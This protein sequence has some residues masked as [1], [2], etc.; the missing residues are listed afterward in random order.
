M[1]LPVR[2]ASS[3]KHFI[4]QIDLRYIK[5]EE[6]VLNYKVC[7]SLVQVMGINKINDLNYRKYSMC[8]CLIMI[9]LDKLLAADT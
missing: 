5:V 1:K 7:I 2:V 3:N 9:N 6:F 8:F 4:M